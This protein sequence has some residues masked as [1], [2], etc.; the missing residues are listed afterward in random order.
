MKP[1][2]S[3]FLLA[4]VLDMQAQSSAQKAVLEKYFFNLPV[5][6]DYRAM[7]RTV[8][9]SAAFG[10]DSVT[11]TGAAHF[12]LAE[13]RARSPFP[14]AAKVRFVS[15]QHIYR[16]TLTGTIY[17]TSTVITAI[18]RFNRS[19]AGAEARDLFYREV[20]K[21]I[22]QGFKC[23]LERVPS[24]TFTITNYTYGLGLPRPVV[25]VAKVYDRETSAYYVYIK[26]DRRRNYEFDKKRVPVIRTF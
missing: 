19:A 21:E 4:C 3:L 12:H 1:L 11:K 20:N 13:N 22:H 9:S 10:A 17:D 18:C 5:C 24:D 25:S 23:R 7:I 15:Y 26:Y 6:G 14:E 2:L 8:D 16:D